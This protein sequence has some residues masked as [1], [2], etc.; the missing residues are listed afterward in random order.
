MKRSRKTQVIDGL[1][2]AIGLGL[3]LCDAVHRTWE[4]LEL[5]EHIAIRR[6][7]MARMKQEAEQA[8]A[9]RANGFDDVVE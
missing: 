7:R 9:A 3:L 2:L 5:R 8:A 1:L 6:Q 4:M